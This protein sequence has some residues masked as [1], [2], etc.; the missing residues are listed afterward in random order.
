M[1]YIVVKDNKV[2]SVNLGRELPEDGIE[3]PEDLAMM[4]MFDES[5]YWTYTDEQVTGTPIVR[6]QPMIS[7]VSIRQARKALYQLGYLTAI[8][9]FMT[10]YASEEERIDWMYATEVRRD[11]PL[12]ENMRLM[13]NLTKE[14]IDNLFE[15]AIT[16]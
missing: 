5:N 12:V 11:H 8:E 15:L 3:I 10:V 14:N 16:L 2:L 7:V 6:P 13:L 1:F 4:I 9:S